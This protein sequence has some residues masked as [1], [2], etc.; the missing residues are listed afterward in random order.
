MQQNR[1]SNVFEIGSTNLH[2]FFLCF[3]N[4]VVF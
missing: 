4:F 2:I 3:N 1:I